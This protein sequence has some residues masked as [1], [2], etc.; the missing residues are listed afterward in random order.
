VP[1]QVAAGA[2]DRSAVGREAGA[3]QYWEEIDATLV[4]A[5]LFQGLAPHS[6]VME[7]HIVGEEVTSRELAG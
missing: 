6:S 7:L 1:A 3:P 2:A 4:V 5:Q